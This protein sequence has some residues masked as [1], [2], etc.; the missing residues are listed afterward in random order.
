MPKDLERAEQLLRG[1]LA[2]PSNL[3][4]FRRRAKLALAERLLR[5][6]ERSEGRALLEEAAAEG[7]LGARVLLA[8]C[9][10]HGVLLTQDIKRGREILEEDVRLGRGMSILDLARELLDHDGP[11]ERDPARVRVLLDEFEV[12]PR[13]TEDVRRDLAE[14][15]VSWRAARRLGGSLWLA[16]LL[17]VALRASQCD[18]VPSTTLWRWVF[19]AAGS[20]LRQA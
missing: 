13:T 3:P 18:D 1:V 12:G 11:L 16:A 15:R 14:L 20:I 5:Q 9:L 7:E 10:L 17:G 6:G 4:Q 8:R 2:S 19:D